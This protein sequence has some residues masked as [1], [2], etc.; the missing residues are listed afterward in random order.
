MVEVAVLHDR[1][2]LLGESLGRAPVLALDGCETPLGEDHRHYGQGARAHGH[3]DG[4]GEYRLGPV[5][6]SLQE[7]GDAFGMEHGRP[8]RAGRAE[9]RQGDLGIVPHL[10]DPWRHR[11]ARR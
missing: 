5:R 1:E 7:V 6:V 4:V 8:V 11:R 3:V 2:G 9:A 10:A